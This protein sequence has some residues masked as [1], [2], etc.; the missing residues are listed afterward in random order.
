MAYSIRQ[1][2]INAVESRLAKIRIENGFETDAGANVT[3]NNAQ[4]ARNFPCL[5]IQPGEEEIDADR[6]RMEFRLRIEGIIDAANET[7]V[8]A[9]ERLLADIVEAMTSREIVVSFESGSL[10]VDPLPGDPV[11][12]ESGSFAGVIASISLSSGAWEDGDAAGAM[13][14]RRCAGRLRAGDTLQF[15]DADFMDIAGVEAILTPEALAAGDLAE[16][17]VYSGGGPL[18]SEEPASALAGAYAEIRIAYRHVAGNPYA[19][20]P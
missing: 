5:D 6:N 4:A 16:N 14:F 15:E 1:R 13:S 11:A 10:A 18:V 17:V 20:K 2:L 9:S 7:G 19:I 3:L 8:A 12:T